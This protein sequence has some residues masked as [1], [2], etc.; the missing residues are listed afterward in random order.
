VDLE[1]LSF[2]SQIVGT[3]TI[4][5]GAI[6]AL[7]QFYE[8]RRQRHEQRAAEIMRGFMDPNFADA[9]ARI[10]VLPDGVSAEELRRAGPEA[11]RAAIRICMSLETMGLMVYRRIVPLELVVE[12]AG[13]MSVMIW[14]KLGPWLEQIRIEQ[15]QPSWAEWFQ[16]LAQQCEKHKGQRAPAHERLDWKP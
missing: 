8:V 9:I 5:G 1:T 14:R 3:L 10:R 7:V 6:F 4:V 13:G 11:E 12:L 2:V 16:W 15:Q